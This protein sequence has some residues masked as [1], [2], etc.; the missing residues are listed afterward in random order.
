MAAQEANSTS[1]TQTQSQARG[2]ADNDS[3]IVVIGGE[4]D[5]AAAA[6]TTTTAAADN[7]NAQT[8][9]THSTTNSVQNG[10]VNAAPVNRQTRFRGPAR[11][12]IPVFQDD[13][14]I[15]IK[16]T[17]KRKGPIDELRF[18]QEKMA[19]TCLRFPHLRPA[20]WR[21]D[22]SLLPKFAGMFDN[23]PEGTAV[24]DTRCDTDDDDDQSP[25]PKGDQESGY[26]SSAS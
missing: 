5:D 17:R 23:L 14:S 25:S 26:S 15:L 16:Q 4:D 24:Y 10:P 7:S 20:G 19:Y 11:L 18:V 13:N 6:A 1:V 9:G 12:P 8:D 2:A 3:G 21:P 22:L